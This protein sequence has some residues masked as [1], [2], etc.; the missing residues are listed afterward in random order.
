MGYVV[1]ACLVLG[2]AAKLFSTVA[3]PFDNLAT[4]RRAPISP[5]PHGLL[6]LSLFFIVAILV[7]KSVWF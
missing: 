1:I 3:V 6:S 7:G 4:C 5:H 2:D